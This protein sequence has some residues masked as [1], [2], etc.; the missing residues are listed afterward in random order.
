MGRLRSRLPT[1]REHRQFRC[2]SAADVRAE[3]VEA[4]W[5]EMAGAMLSLARLAGMLGILSMVMAQYHL[6]VSSNQESLKRVGGK[7]VGDHP[8]ILEKV[9][10]TF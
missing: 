10:S 1:H 4:A 9:S 3:R 2:G 5:H 7:G 8:E 6:K